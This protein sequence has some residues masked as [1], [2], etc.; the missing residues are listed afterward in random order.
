MYIFN[1][2]Q[3][4]QVVDCFIHNINTMDWD[5]RAATVAKGQILLYYSGQ[6]F[7]KTTDPA[8]TYMKLPSSNNKYSSSRAFTAG[9]G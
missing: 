2:Y 9:T 7:Y 4:Y 8:G 1:Y 3:V 6:T 5:A